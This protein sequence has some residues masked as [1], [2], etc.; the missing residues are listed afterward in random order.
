MNVDVRRVEG[1]HSVG[2]G[3]R[4]GGH[5]GQR[6]AGHC[7]PRPISSKDNEEKSTQSPPWCTSPWGREVMRLG[8]QAKE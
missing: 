7:I 5:A 4:P 8:F 3:G 1:P 6:L 2:A